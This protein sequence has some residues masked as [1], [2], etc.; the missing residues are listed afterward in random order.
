[1]PRIKARQFMNRSVYAVAITLLVSAIAVPAIAHM[2]AK[3]IVKERMEVMMAIGKAMK[4]MSSMARGKTPMNAANV[5]ASAGEV[6]AHGKRIVALFPEGSGGGVS[7]A[8]PEIWQDPDGFRR[9]ADELVSAA[10]ALRVAAAS[11]DTD[12]IKTAF[13]ALG[14]TCGGCHRKYRVKKK[15]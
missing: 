1:M 5:A 6:A 14:K 12:A 9:S 8:T 4:S 3:G 2:G 13:R 10:E 11:T 15:R 7:E